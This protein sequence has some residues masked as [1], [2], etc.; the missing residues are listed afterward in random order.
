MK[1]I[2]KMGALLVL[3]FIVAACSG[4]DAYQGEWKAKDESSTEYKVVFQPKNITITDAQGKV[5]MNSSY[6][7]YSVKTV[8]GI[9]TYGIE[10]QDGS[11]YFIHFPIKNNTVNAQLIIPPQSTS[12][13]G[14]TITQGSEEVLSLSR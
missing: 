7:Q 1:F 12:F 13:G 2:I 11:E 6:T 8:N 9:T 14:I 3:M 4:S 10:L 5:V